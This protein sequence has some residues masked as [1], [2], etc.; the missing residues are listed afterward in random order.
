MY[1]W[2]AMVVMAFGISFW[3]D[4]RSLW[5]PILLLISVGMIFLSIANFFMFQGSMW[6]MM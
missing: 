4:N 3:R 1:F 5:N 6:L 2:T